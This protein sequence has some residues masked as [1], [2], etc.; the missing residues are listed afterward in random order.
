M[1]RTPPDLPA[2][3]PALHPPERLTVRLR[4]ITPMFGGSAETRTVDEHH[5]VRA[6]SVRGHLRFWWRATAGAAYDTS[7]KLHEA[8]SALWGNTERH[9]RVRVD[10]EMTDAGQA[11]EPVRHVRRGNGK[12]AFD[13]GS[14][15]AYALFPFQGT[16]KYGDTDE[17]PAQARKNVAFTLNLSLGGLNA[18][19]RREVET[20]L[21][22]WVLFGGIGSRTR[23]GCGSLELVGAEAQLPQP[24]QKG[25]RLLTTLPGRY[26][27]GKPQRDPLQAWA[28]AV[29]VYRDFR[30]GVG[31]ARNKGQQAN[32]PGR[33]RYPEPDTLREMTRR[34]G[35]EVIHPVRGFPRADLGLPI[36]FHFQDAQKKGEPT[37]QTLQ[38]RQ[39]G[40]QR[41]ASPVITKVARIGG[42]YLPLVLVLNSPNVWDG[43]GVELKGRG[44]VRR[45]QVDLNSE[46]LRQIPPL[47]GLPIRKA[48]ERRLASLEAEDQDG[49]K[50]GEKVFREVSL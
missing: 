12:V 9:G 37:D 47:E 6:A 15:P 16:I 21:H 20:A 49:R 5:P 19:E 48:F 45:E 7:K 33:S 1:P 36:I 34:Y 28:T 14:Y 27:A 35:H 50:T 43:P 2:N 40:Q 24:E 22:A 39:A 3:L 31:F 26:F 10:V 17:A 11:C 32:R 13:F 18:Q 42:E 25:H 23:R 44:E 29:G 38:G 8:E 46:T 30:Q 4:T 41:F